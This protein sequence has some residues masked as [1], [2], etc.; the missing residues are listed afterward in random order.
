MLQGGSGGRA[1]SNEDFENLYKALWA[2]GGSLQASNIEHALG[3]ISDVQQR[4][5][6]VKAL[7]KR[8]E[9]VSNMVIDHIRSL[10]SGRRLFLDSQNL[11]RQAKVYGTNV[12]LI[13]EK[14]DPYSKFPP[15]TGNV[16]AG[17]E[18]TNTIAQT[19]YHDVVAAVDQT[20][21]SLWTRKGT[22]N[23]MNNM[24]LQKPHKY[25]EETAQ[26]PPPQLGYSTSTPTNTE[27]MITYAKKLQY[28]DDPRDMK[29]YATFGLEISEKGPRHA[30]DYI[31]GS[32]QYFMWSKF[33]YGMRKLDNTKLLHFSG[34]AALDSQIKTYLKSNKFK[35]IKS[36]WKKVAIKGGAEGAS[37][38]GMID[39]FEK[40]VEENANKNNITLSS[41]TFLYRL[42]PN[43]VTPYMAKVFQ[44]QIK[45]FGQRH[46]AES[47]QNLL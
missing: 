27:R 6:I 29:W 17:N 3:I 8:G 42:M 31:A 2:G 1:I 21:E 45:R 37:M 26:T 20:G 34:G 10:Q 19:L 18:Y 32:L 23:L 43:S 13:K 15:A 41:L 9:A 4:F 33:M 5:K 40:N 25:L 16:H 30:A 44:E 24:K 36:E 47:R 11:K 38:Q 22:S 39:A 35:E 7:S 28:S 46:I 12:D 14:Y